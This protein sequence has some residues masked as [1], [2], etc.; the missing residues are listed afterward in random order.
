MP[1]RVILDTDIGTDPDDALA[2]ALILE[3]PELTLEGITCVYGDAALRARI[4]QKLLKLRGIDIPVRAGASTTLT[5]L[6]PATMMGHEGDGLLEPGDE[7][8]PIHPEYAPDF[9]ARTALEN[10]GEIHLICIAPLT[11]VALALLRAPRLPLAHLT[12]MG[13]AIRGTNHLDLGYTENNIAADAEAA[14]IVMTSGIPITLVPLDVTTRVFI[15]RE[16][17]KRI[18]TGGTAYHEALARQV[19]LFPWVRDYGESHLHDPL[20]VTTLFQP[21]LVTLRA[22]H[23]DIETTGRLTR[24]ATLAQA[25]TDKAPANAQVALEVEGERAADFILGRV[26]R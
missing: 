13:G 15:R 5:G 10:P 21:N 6:Q 16:D 12:I 8:L 19:E 17:T 1:I 22:L 9:I 26:A 25:P 18:R 7:G 14:H 3:S 4:A 23:V 24:G 2:L 20:A 11:N